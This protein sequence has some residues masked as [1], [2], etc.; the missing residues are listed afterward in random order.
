MLA[1]RRI[2]NWRSLPRAAYDGSHDKP[3]TYRDGI[4]FNKSDIRTG[5]RII[6]Y[7][8]RASKTTWIVNAIWTI[9]GTGHDRVKSSIY[10]VRTLDDRLDLRCEETG[11]WR[12]MAFMYLVYSSLWRLRDEGDSQ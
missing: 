12:T 9:T 11:E 1:R 4:F 10:D 3:E 2:E 8:R 6:H 7:G 5:S